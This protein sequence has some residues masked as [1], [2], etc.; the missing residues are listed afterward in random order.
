MNWRHAS[1]KG[2]PEFPWGDRNP[3]GGYKVGD[4]VGIIH[5]DHETYMFDNPTGKIVRLQDDGDDTPTVV[6]LVEA[7]CHAGDLY[8]INREEK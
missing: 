4:E 8:L 5:S 6:V 2:T 1:T 7:Y 3:E